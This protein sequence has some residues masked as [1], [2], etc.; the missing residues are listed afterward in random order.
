MKL[1]HLLFIT[2]FL[3]TGLLACGGPE[4]ADDGAL[5]TSADAIC[6][7]PP[8]ATPPPPPPAPKP[9]LVPEIAS[10][11]A[12]PVNNGQ[13]VGVRVRNSGTASAVASVLRVSVKSYSGIQFIERVRYFRVGGIS[14]GQ[15]RDLGVDLGDG[16]NA[17]PGNGTFLPAAPMTFSNS[18]VLGYPAVEWTVSVD[19]A[20]GP[21]WFGTSLL[22]YSP[23]VSELSE[24]NNTIRGTSTSC[25]F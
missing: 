15:T 23:S 20:F 14:A 3:A 25:T 21:A 4:D 13:L 6:A 19:T 1:T 22:S 12:C 18:P 16:V 2:P 24:S 5:D 9:D 11:A 17:V 10:G 8:C 7:D